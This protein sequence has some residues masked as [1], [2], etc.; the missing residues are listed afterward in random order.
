[1][2]TV[3]GLAS[4]LAV[5]AIGVISP[6]PS[7]ILVARTAVAVSRRAAA[8]SALGMAAG[9]SLLSVA[10]LVGLGA[11]LREI[12]AAFLALKWVGGAYLVWLGWKTWRGAG[13]SL[14]VAAGGAVPA[15]RPRRHFFVALA[16]MLGNPKAAVVYGVIFA[17]LLPRTPTRALLLA[18]P[19]AIFVME[20]AWY[21]LVAYALSSPRTRRAYLRAASAIDRV[22][23]AVLGL[24]GLRLLLSPR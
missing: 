19:P 10:A 7:F 8:A 11:I 12:P 5:L 9:A 2:D 20:G 3:L 4:I 6:G 15:G 13:A 22:A 1:M 21:L 17:A 14:E 23:G 24:L 16:T 18:L